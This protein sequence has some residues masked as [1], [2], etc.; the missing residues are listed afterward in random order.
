MLEHE[1]PLNDF[2]RTHAPA[3]FGSVPARKLSGVGALFLNLLKF[4]VVCVVMI[5]IVI[6]T[7]ERKDWYPTICQ[8]IIVW[9]FVCSVMWVRNRLKKGKSRGSFPIADSLSGQ[10]DRYAGSA[11]RFSP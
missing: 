6:A 4:L 5:G 11:S 1:T 2:P 9:I 7:Y 3:L 8:G 10:Q